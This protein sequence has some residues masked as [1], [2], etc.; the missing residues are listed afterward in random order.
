MF[1]HLHKIG[2]SI[3][4]KKQ[5]LQ[6]IIK[7]V[8]EKSKQNIHSSFVVS[9]LNITTDKTFGTTTLLES[10]LKT[11]SDIRKNNILNNILET[12][13]F[14]YDSW[15]ITF[16][17]K[18]SEILEK[19]LKLKELDSIIELGELASVQIFSDILESQNFH[20]TILSNPVD[21]K[22]IDIDFDSVSEK[23]KLINTF[24]DHYASYT[25]HSATN[26][27]FP[28]FFSVGKQGTINLINRGYTDT[29]GAIIASALEFDRYN[30][31]KESGGVFTKNPTKFKTAKHLDYITMNETKLLTSFGNDVVNQ[32][33]SDIISEN[34]VN[35][36][37]KDANTKRGF[38]TKI[39]SSNLIL[40][41]DEKRTS[42]ITSLS[43]LSNLFI[44]DYKLPLHKLNLDFEPILV[45]SNKIKT[46][47]LLPM[48]KIKSIEYKDICR[49]RMNRS[50]ISCI[51][52]NMAGN[53]GIASKIM[54]V[55]SRNAI[56]IE[57]IYQGSD[58]TCIVIVIKSEHEDK[59][60]RAL[61]DFFIKN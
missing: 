19:S 52:E 53:V 3:I 18:V 25:N 16:N 45:N 31:W 54:N 60:I 10:L 22:N 9:A 29:T 34:E 49:T 42:K 4:G 55:L 33:A 2:G 8:G 35:L 59:S 46:S 48:Y 24:K 57:M 30:I 26:L 28:G 14:I 23:L 27:I 43:S 1:R 47:C 11:N 40:E 32:Y 15:N 44:V 20:T 51:G 12:H 56:N 21:L 13:E 38:D 6:N 37:I 5:L 50:L 17:P 36:F 58:E 7:D 61:H 39:I 41:E